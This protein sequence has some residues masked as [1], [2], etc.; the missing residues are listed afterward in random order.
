V[1]PQEK[2]QKIVKNLGNFV[3]IKRKHTLG[4]ADAF[5]AKTGEQENKKD[6]E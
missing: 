2:R 3:R 6:K 4:E 5:K 1:K